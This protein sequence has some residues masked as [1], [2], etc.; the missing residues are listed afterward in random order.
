MM[1][2]TNEQMR[3]FFVGYHG[4]HEFFERAAQSAV[5]DI[6]SRIRSVQ[7]DPLNPVG[8]RNAE[9]VLFSRNKNITR[10]HIRDALYGDK[11][12]IDGWDKMMCIYPVSEFNKFAYVRKHMA[13]DYNNV[14][15]WRRQTECMRS[16]DDV[17][18]YINEHGPVSASDIPSAKTNDG[19]WGPT[20]VAGVCCEYLWHCGRIVTADKK[21]VVK[22][23]DTTEKALGESA[24][25]NAF[26]NEHDFWLWYVKRRIAAVGAVRNKNGGAWLGAFLEK[27]EIRTPIINEL[28]ERGEIVAVEADGEKQPFYVCAGEEQRFD[29]CAGDRAVFIAPLDNMMW[30]RKTIKDIFDFDYSWE[31]YVPAGRRKYGYY[32]LPVLIGN[33]FAGRIEPYRTSDGTLAVKNFWRENDCVLRD[34]DIELIAREFQ[35]LAIFTDSR[36]ETD[37]I[38]KLYKDSRE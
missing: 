22:I 20:K 6:F 28:A 25:V 38:D 27:P 36:A 19:R 29:I 34:G 7:Y 15:L 3:N 23:Y 24:D 13:S 5:G 11:R 8:C 4:F 2:V 31:V 18:A 37:M 30:D 16:A 1:R 9:L 17:Y 12:L 14:L 35:R 32:V 26:D 21:G 33:R 10:A